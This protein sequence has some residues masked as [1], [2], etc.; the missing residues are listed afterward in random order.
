MMFKKKITE[1]DIFEVFEK[2]AHE[3][4]RF[5]KLPPLDSFYLSLLAKCNKMEITP[6]IRLFGYEEALQENRYLNSHYPD[7]AQRLWIIGD[8]GQG[9][10]WFLDK[11]KGCILFYDHDQ[12]EYSNMQQFICLEISFFEFLQMAFLCKEVEYYITENTM[13][14]NKMEAFK[15]AIDSIKDNLYELYPFKY[16]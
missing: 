12:G 4:K 15:K 3:I 6:D 11:E 7:I 8:T 1:Q 10:S 14:T 16:F 2:R 9:D 13:D 5:D